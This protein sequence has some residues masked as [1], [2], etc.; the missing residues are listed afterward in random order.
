MA[1][2]RAPRSMKASS[3]SSPRSSLPARPA[4]RDSAFSTGDEP[5]AAGE[6]RLPRLAFRTCWVACARCTA[7]R[8]R[9]AAPPSATR[10]GATGRIACRCR[11]GAVTGG[12][13][14]RLSAGRQPRAAACR[15][16]VFDVAA[17]CFR[18]EP[19]RSLDRLQS[20]R[21]REFVRIGTPEEIT[22]FREDWMSRAQKACARD[23]GLPCT[24]DV[25]NDPFFGRVGQM[26]AVSPATEL[27]Q[28]RT[29]DPVLRPAPQPTACMS[30]NYHQEHFG[31]VWGLHNERR[32][33]QPYRLRGVRDG[34]T[35]G[36]DVRH[37][38]RR[39][40]AL[41]GH[42]APSARS[43]SRRQRGPRAASGRRR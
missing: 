15:R 16:P 26:M 39:S 13:L 35:R 40:G 6:V 34:P 21:M 20:F 11:S 1:S 14:P 3:R 23:L 8:P 32:R 24:L 41:A 42:G 9:S 5:Q 28:V 18:H 38:R 12:L 37:P 7:R 30:F 17:D 2:T 33:A 4:R 36:G 43:V 19:S 22:G 31:E 10:P 25:A 27:A 29:A